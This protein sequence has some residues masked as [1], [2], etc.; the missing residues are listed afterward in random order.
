MLKEETSNFSSVLF[1]CTKFSPQTDLWAPFYSGALSGLE[2]RGR[3]GHDL[4]LALGIPARFVCL[5][6]I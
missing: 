2:L 3:V 6:E 5:C 4:P 1:M